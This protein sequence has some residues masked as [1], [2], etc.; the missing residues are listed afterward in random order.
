MCSSDLV[1]V[2]L[3]MCACRCVCHRERRIV[4]AAHRS[5]GQPLRPGPSHAAAAAAATGKWKPSAAAA[6][7]T[8]KMRS[9]AA[10]AE[11]ATWRQSYFVAATTMISVL[12]TLLAFR[13]L[14]EGGDS[15]DWDWDLVL[16]TSWDWD[17]MLRSDEH[18]HTSTPSAPTTPHPASPLRR[19]LSARPGPLFS[20][21]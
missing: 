16:R 20:S 4:P 6:A 7:P 18:L 19:P 15:L 14:V 12:Q 2:T 10:T 11:A 8:K 21:M 3:C 9:S 1:C 5:T 13:H 17:L